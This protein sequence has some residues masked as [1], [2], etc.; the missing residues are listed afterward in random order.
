M[1][2]IDNAMEK[3]DRAEPSLNGFG[4]G[5]GLANQ[6][7]CRQGAISLTR[8]KQSVDQLEI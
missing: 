5:N 1:V 6:P 7:A 4:R 2:D 8:R 3:S